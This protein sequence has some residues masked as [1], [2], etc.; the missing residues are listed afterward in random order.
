MDDRHLRCL[1]GP[2][3]TDEV[4]PMRG[5]FVDV[6]GTRLYYYAAGTR[7]GGDPVVFLHGFPG[8]SHGWRLTV[9]L[10]P[11][12]HRLVVPDLMGSGRSDGPGRLGG[13][14]DDHARLVTGLLDDLGIDRAALVGH[15]FGGAV[16]LS[17][18]AAHPG[19]VS[20][21]C[22]ISTP[23]WAEWPRRLARLARVAA[24]LG[25]VLGAAV[26]ASF[27]H[28]SA[29][30]GFANREAGRRS[31][32][33]SLRASAARLGLDAIRANLRAQH[34]PAIAALAPRL[35]AL[36]VPVA[37]LWGAADPF[38]DA[39]VGRRLQAAIPGAT[40]EVIPGARHF[41]AEDAPDQCARAI[42]AVLER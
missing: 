16:A 19:R 6:G 42:R 35:G 13:T 36:R 25:S 7:D 15:G 26:L 22:L 27:V 40:F 14:L 2:R 10:M 32:D 30:C 34:D 28:G 21:L 5:E 41:V 31:L 23:A 24:P 37:V 12:G 11:A 1:C 38:L 4:P 33:V 20:A 29:L 39:S 8:S 17:V 18:A 9:Q 3:E